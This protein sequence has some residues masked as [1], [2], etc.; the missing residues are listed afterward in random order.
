VD[1]LITPHAAIDVRMHVY[2]KKKGIALFFSLQM[3]I[4]FLKRS[5]LV[6]HSLL[7]SLINS[8]TLPLPENSVTI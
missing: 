4:Q 5:Y 7:G 1:I 3:S 8:V 6:V 2:K